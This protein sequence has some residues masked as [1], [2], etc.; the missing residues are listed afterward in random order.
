MAQGDFIYFFFREVALE[1][2]NCGKVSIF[3][4][5]V[6]HSNQKLNEKVQIRR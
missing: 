3:A 1:H 4:I 6:V 2:V 5:K